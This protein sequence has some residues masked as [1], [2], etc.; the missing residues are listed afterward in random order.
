MPANARFAVP[1]LVAL[2]AAAAILAAVYPGFMSYDSVRALH[3]ARTAVQGGDYPPFVSYVWRVFDS[4]WPGPALMLFAQNFLL[5]LAFA[6]ILRLLHYPGPLIVLGVALFCAAPPILGPMLVVWKDIGVSACLCAAVTCW[7]VAD[8][9]PKAPR[10]RYRHRAAVRCCG[11][12][13]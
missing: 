11:L 5:L 10:D 8:T 7:L 3:E 1:P 4:V 12:P 9:V 13:A 2:T 6:T